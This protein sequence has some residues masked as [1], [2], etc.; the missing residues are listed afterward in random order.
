[1]ANLPG[2]REQIHEMKYDTLVRGVGASVIGQKTKLFS[3]L[4]TGQP[5]LT[6]MQEGGR[7]SNEEVFLC[8]AIQFYTQFAT[9]QLYRFIEDGIMWTFLVGN[10]PMMGA[11][12]LW[13]AP[14]GGG[15]YGNDVNAQA[16]VITNGLPSWEAILKLAKPIKVEKNQHFAVDVEFYA[17]AS[18]DN[19]ATPA[20]NPLTVLN[21]DVGLK[22]VKCT[23][24]GILERAV[25]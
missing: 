12:P 2:Y 24:S 3:A 7:L 8:L 1:M 25:Q 20:I 23:I 6:N 4:N 16:H 11:L 17:F 21:A 13:T 22:I 9:A 10:K 14:G 19:G 5:Q 18:L 15:M